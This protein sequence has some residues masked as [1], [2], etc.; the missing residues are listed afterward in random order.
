MTLTFPQ[1][2]TGAFAQFPLER[3]R[4]RR[5]VCNILAGGARFRYA[6]S[7]SG[8]V[9]WE[10]PLRALD[11]AEI[12]RISDL[13][14][15]TEGRLRTFTFLDPLS[16]LLL[17]SEDYAKPAWQKDPFVQ[18]TPAMADPFGG[19]RA[20]RVVNA[21]QAAQRL[22]QSVAAPS[23]FV[24]CFSLYARSDAGTTLTLVRASAA[25]ASSSIHPLTAEWTRISSAGVLGGAD[26]S[27]AFGI[28][29]PA[30]GAVEIFGTQV[31]AQVAPSEYMLARASAGVYPAARFD[32]DALS[33]VAQ[34][35]GASDVVVRIVSPEVG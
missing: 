28:E 8:L 23:S 6:D 12:A 14:S 32:Q 4:V 30:G 17:W 16:N 18:L 15:A 34:A 13:F 2:N 3:R 35:P 20:T 5:T 24:Y 25:A 11:D 31:E 10:L 1:L 26:G 7:G 29:L 33:V 21:G 27:V 22:S 9:R 19:S